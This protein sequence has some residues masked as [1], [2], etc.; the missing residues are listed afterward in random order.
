MPTPTGLPKV[1]ERIRLYNPVS[2][3]LPEY[4]KV[5]E[6]NGGVL[7]Q[8]R[9]HWENAPPHAKNPSWLTDAHF[10]FTKGWLTIV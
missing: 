4:G 8:V 2:M 9:V 10:H 7:W 1:H 3:D 5:L 6:R